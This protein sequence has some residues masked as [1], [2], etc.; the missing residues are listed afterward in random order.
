[1]ILGADNQTFF[2]NM[3]ML[4]CGLVKMWTSTDME[5][6]LNGPLPKHGLP[7]LPKLSLNT[8]GFAYFI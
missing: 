2:A 3:E 4:L 6:R 5:P 7:K 8:S 1:L